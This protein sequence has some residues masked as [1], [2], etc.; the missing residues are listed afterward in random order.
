MPCKC[1]EEYWPKFSK[2][3]E[4]YKA[5]EPVP[6]HV[7]NFEFGRWVKGPDWNKLEAFLPT[8]SKLCPEAER[9]LGNPLYQE[10]RRAHL[11]SHPEVAPIAQPLPE[12]PDG[13]LK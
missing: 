3:W 10:K 11:L 5:Q 13:A 8:C 12:G 1:E 6:I 2:F 4:D 7:E 9:R